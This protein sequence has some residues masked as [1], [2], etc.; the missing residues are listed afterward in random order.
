MPPIRLLVVEGNARPARERHRATYG[1]TPAASYAALLRRHEPETV[2]DIIA[3]ADEDAAVPDPAGLDGYDGVVLTGS[4]LTLWKAEPPAMRQVDLMREVFRAG[5][6]VFGSCWGL[7]VA[8]VAAGGS[9]HANPRGREVGI[10]RDIA[11][12]GAGRAHPMYEGKPALFASP[13]VHADEIEA[14]PPDATVLAG[15]AMSPVQAAEIR[16][17]G[18]LFWGVQYHPEF[19][20]NELGAIMRRYRPILLEEGTFRTPEAADGWL[21]DLEALGQNPARR[22]LSWRYG[23]G[24]DILDAGRRESEIGRFLE[25]RVRPT[26]SQRGR[27]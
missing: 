2:C 21:A 27:A 1:L 12:T 8:A 15:N 10:A 23:I 20:L 7:Q 4:G 18:G 9:V 11:L 14:L 16:H 5:V 25:C 3:P 6:P 24:P 13:C 22:D 17:E 19:S 26:R